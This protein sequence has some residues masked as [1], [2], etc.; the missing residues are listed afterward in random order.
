ME[1]LRV[2]VIGCGW[3]GS[4][5]A[6]VYRELG[7]VE[8]TAVADVDEVKARRIGERYGARA[9]SDPERM[10]DRENLDAVSVVVTPQHLARTAAAAAERG[11][12]VLVEKPVAT[13]ERELEDLISAARRGGAVVVPGFIELFNPGY[14]A[15]K[16]TVRRGEIGDPY[17]I[18]GKRIGRSPK[19]DVRWEI[20]VTLDLAIHEA[21][22]QMDLLGREPNS[23]R[24]FVSYAT[25]RERED[26]ALLVMD[27]PGSVIGIIEV[28]W[29]TPVGVR[30]LRISG[31]EGSA[32]LDYVS[33]RL[34]VEH[35]EGAT[36]PRL[37]WR[38]PLMEEL[39]YFVDHVRN[40]AEPEIGIEFAS[41]VLRTIF[42]GLRNSTVLGTGP[43][44]GSARK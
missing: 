28:N 40:S 1:R 5:H 42:S 35:K 12:G 31:S 4:A 36:I 44:G 39:G 9:Y 18:S 26:V 25:S 37:Y 38:E 3:F 41:K 2:G 19:R 16:E 14:A 23:V 43:R 27:Y 21:Y 17:L 15:L 32:E 8:L 33:Q 24:T 10:L 11:V 13:S 34:T 7:G 29:L 20:G 30:S 6:R 22:V